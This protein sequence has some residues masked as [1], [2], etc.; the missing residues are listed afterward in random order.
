MAN[1]KKI[2]KL[3]ELEQIDG[4]HI[5]ETVP[6]SL[7]AIVSG[8]VTLGKYK[9]LNK[10]S[11][12]EELNNY[13]TAELR[14][15]AIKV[16]IIPNTDVNRLKKSLLKEFDKFSLGAANPRKPVSRNL[17]EDKIKQG[18]KIMSAVK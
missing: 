1:I 11:Y 7:E 18:L 5:E 14:Q 9:T 3:S 13:N 12:I 15:H 4:Q 2:N 6:S 10:D 8:G 17:P 16:G